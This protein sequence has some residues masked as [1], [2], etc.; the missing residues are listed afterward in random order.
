[1]KLK[2]IISILFIIA[3]T[4]TAIHEIEH[5]KQHDSSTCQ[6]CIVDDHS[7]SADIV[8][9]FK[10]VEIFSSAKEIPLNLISSLK[11]KRP[12]NRSRAPPILS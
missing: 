8:D 4:F 6:V 10:D 9:D 1:M 2:V 7:V 3:T 11:I 5:V 12:A